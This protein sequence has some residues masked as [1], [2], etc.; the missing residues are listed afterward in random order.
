M[1]MKTRSTPDMPL[2]DKRTRCDPAPMHRGES[3]FQFLN[4]VDTPY[5]QRVRDLLQAWLQHYPPGARADLTQ[6][7][8]S[9]ADSQH[10]PAFWELYLHE[11]LRRDGWQVTVHPALQSTSIRP[12]FLATRGPEALFME[13]TAIVKPVL[14]ERQSKHFQQVLKGVDD[15]RTPDFSLGVNYISVGSRAPSTR[16]LRRDLAVWLGGLDCEG[17][18]R[19]LRAGDGHQVLP[20]YSWTPTPDWHLI[21]HAFPLKKGASSRPEFRPVGMTGPGFATSVDHRGPLKGRLLEKLQ[22]LKEIPHSLV[23]AVLDLSEY[24]FYSHECD[25]ALY[26]QTV[27]VH[28]PMTLQEVSA[29]REKDGFWSIGGRRAALVSGVLVCSGLRPW[30][31][32][33]REGATP[34]LWLNGARESRAPRLPWPTSALGPDGLSVLSTLPEQEMFELFGVAPEWPGPGPAYPD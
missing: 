4:R 14:S 34:V 31:I 29:Y 33:G 10:L 27:G 18:A 25:S 26:G 17:L 23:I 15:L 32:C 21:F 7:L 5:W 11:A 8:R 12:D 13:A 24:P 20:T 16:R 9:D 22:R 28:N 2:F 1:V 19:D 3:S 6:R 30:T